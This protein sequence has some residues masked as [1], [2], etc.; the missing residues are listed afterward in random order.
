MELLLQ[1][2]RATVYKQIKQGKI[3]IV[4][5]DFDLLRIDPKAWVLK[6]EAPNKHNPLIVKKAA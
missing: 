5:S 3:P 1:C 2:K 6:L 4:E